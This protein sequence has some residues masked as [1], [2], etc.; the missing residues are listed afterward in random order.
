MLRLEDPESVLERLAT[1]IAEA[2]RL[3][4]EGK[5]LEDVW[6][7]LRA[8]GYDIMDS[9]QVTMRVTDLSGREAKSA[10]RLSETWADLGP[11]HE[12]FVDEIIEAALEL[13]AEASVAGKSIAAGP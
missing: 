5:S 1:P 8:A 11:E 10:L 6:G 13:E 7:Y 3:L 2:R 12:R 9:R 4:A